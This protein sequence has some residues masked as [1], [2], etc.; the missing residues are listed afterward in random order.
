MARARTPTIG[1]EHATRLTGALR[2]LARTPLDGA[3]GLPELTGLRA[4]PKPIFTLPQDNVILG[5]I[6]VLA[7]SGKVYAHGRDVV[8]ETNA[9]DGGGQTLTHLRIGS[10][11]Q[12]GAECRLANLFTCRDGETQF[13]PPR[14][15]AHVLLTSDLLYERLP[16]IRTYANRPVFDANFHLRPPGWSEG[17]GIL[18][19]GPHVEP[20]PPEPA[21][22]NRTALDR[23]PRHLRELLG[24]FCFRSCADVA[25]ALSMLLTGLLA[26]HFV[27]AG[28]GV[29][30]LDGNQPG[31]G[32][33]LLVRVAGMVLDGAD[34][35]L[36]SYAA[37]DEELLKRICAL[38]RGSLQSLVLVDNA[39]A[40][41]GGVISSPAV[42][43]NSVAPTLALRILG[44]SET[45]A[46]PNDLLWVLTMND[47]RVSPDLASRG[48]PVRLAYEGRAEARA[49]P[50][51]DPVRYARQHRLEILGELAGMVVSWNRAG[52]PTGPRSHRCHEWAGVVG[53]ILNA[54]GFSEFLAN[55]DEAATAFNA[56]LDE[57]AGLA[58][59]VVV[60]GGPFIEIHHA[61]EE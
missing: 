12:P 5:A 17:P 44:R 42:E 22:P 49:F 3:R 37:D 47:T 18:V 52:R 8:Y 48:V 28:K 26:N 19:H 29:F 21:D 59:V 61:N 27:E 35:R 41:T 38:L 15:F 46:R 57:L 40:T 33:T 13:P 50:G 20:V 56:Q 6:G 16:R 54:A 25:N 24:G 1:D 43:A 32:K 14:W 45:I 23:L 2:A 7:A 31:L 39:K 10:E 55:A 4:P 34:P 58:E 36:I 11:V 9:L 30:L 51:P 60:S 53:G